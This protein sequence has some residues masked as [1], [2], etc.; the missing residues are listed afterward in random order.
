MVGVLPVCARRLACTGI[1]EASCQWSE[2][3]KMWLAVKHIA[4]RR[5][6]AHPRDSDEP[7]TVVDLSSGTEIIRDQ[8]PQ[9]TSETTHICYDA[10]TTGVKA[11]GY[12]SE[13]WMAALWQVRPGEFATCIVA[14]VLSMVRSS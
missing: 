2:P 14:F 12:F 5:P 3:V 4:Y 11:V 1:M 6:G 10:L 13:T 7:N 9:D 8:A